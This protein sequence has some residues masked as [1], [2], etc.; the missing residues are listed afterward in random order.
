MKPTS[1]YRVEVPLRSAAMPQG[2][3]AAQNASLGRR[4][5]LRRSIASSSSSSP[6]SDWDAFNAAALKFIRERSERIK[7]VDDA[8]DAAMEA[9]PRLPERGR[10]EKLGSTFSSSF[11]AHEAAEA[12]A[13]SSSSSS[14]AS[15]TR[16]LAVHLPTTA[17][18]STSYPPPFSLEA[19][20]DWH[21]R[22][23]AALGEAA[24]GGSGGGEPAI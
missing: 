5:L 20:D 14:S 9:M 19:F 16:E 8:V 10:E 12:A 1:N 22:A 15:S 7:R 3:P 23:W 2:A 18:T 13:A 6:S 11:S 21:A 24:Q 4:P 17:T